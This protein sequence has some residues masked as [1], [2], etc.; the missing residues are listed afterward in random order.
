MR[1]TQERLAELFDVLQ[2]AAT[3]APELAS[4]LAELVGRRAHCTRM[5]AERLAKLGGLRD[6]VTV[7]TAADV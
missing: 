3:T 5:I 2:H 7:Q 6:D 4:Y 1:L